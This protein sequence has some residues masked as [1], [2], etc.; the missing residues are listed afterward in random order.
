MK[1]LPRIAAV[2][3]AVSSISIMFVEFLSLL[4]DFKRCPMWIVI[5]RFNMQVKLL[6]H[7]E[8]LSP[9]IMSAHIGQQTDIAWSRE[10]SGR[11]MQACMCYVLAV[12]PLD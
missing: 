11:Q 7:S 8:I 10:Q 3:I 9:I 6:Y 5:R 12:F 4:V 2:F 1:F